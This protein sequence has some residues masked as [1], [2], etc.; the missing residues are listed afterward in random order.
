M[1]QTY[2]IFSSAPYQRLDK[3]DV[4]A[5]LFEVKTFSAIPRGIDQR[6][7]HIVLETSSNRDFSNK[8]ICKNDNNACIDRN[9]FLYACYV[10]CFI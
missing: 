7:R 2:V 6:V 9:I 1:T 5:V 3:H 4:A 10:V 8:E